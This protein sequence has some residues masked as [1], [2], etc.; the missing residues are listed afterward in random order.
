MQQTSKT[1]GPLFRSRNF[2]GHRWRSLSA[3]RLVSSAG[4]PTLLHR[5]FRVQP[6][7]TAA[8]PQTVCLRVPAASGVLVSPAAY[9]ATVHEAELQG[10][11]EVLLHTTWDVSI[12]TDKAGLKRALLYWRVCG[13]R[14][15][16]LAAVRR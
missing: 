15:T 13:Q 11:L 12:G 16:H 5:R 14:P 8:T 1:N 7:A 9:E 3:G 4:K 6:N 2:P 10:V